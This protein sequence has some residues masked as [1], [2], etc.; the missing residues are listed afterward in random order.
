L[1]IVGLGYLQGIFL[2]FLI[3]V[4]GDNMHFSRIKFSITAAIASIVLGSSASLAADMPMK[5]PPPV[6]PVCNW[7]GFYIGGNAGGGWSD[8]RVNFGGDAAGRTLAAIA[9]G[10]LPASLSTSP[11]GFIGGAQAGYN[12]QSGN[13]V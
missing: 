2:D 13:I 3:F 4:S 7:C 6:V 5:A 9:R 8:D 12:V 11:S 10:Q 1:L